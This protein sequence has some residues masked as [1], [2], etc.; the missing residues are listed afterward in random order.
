MILSDALMTYVP[1]ALMGVALW[2]GYRHGHQRGY[3]KGVASWSG[4]SSR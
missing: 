3:A 1:V 2:V 4:S